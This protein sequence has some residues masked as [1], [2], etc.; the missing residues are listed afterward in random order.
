MRLIKRIKKIIGIADTFANGCYIAG[1]SLICERPRAK[2]S[3]VEKDILIIAN[4][5]SIKKTDLTHFITGE[6]DIAVLNDY[7]I[8]VKDFWTIKPK[9]LVIV[10]PVYFIDTIKTDYIID[11]QK[12]MTNTLRK[13]DWEFHVIT[14]FGNKMPVKNA[15][16]VYEWLPVTSFP[17]DNFNL[18]CKLL[19]KNRFAQVG[20][21][22]VMGAAL[23]YFITNMTNSVYIA[24]W[25]MSEFVNIRIDKNNILWYDDVHFYDNDEKNKLNTD[26][27]GFVKSGDFYIHMKNYS[28]AFFQ[29]KLLSDYSKWMHTRIINLSPYSF[30]DVF[31]KDDRYY[32]YGENKKLIYFKSGR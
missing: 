28:D 18:F 13:I 23:Y 16:I 4:G 17:R 32:F 27:V 11:T 31:E 3:K 26:D 6:Y 14:V 10:D 20:Y 7:P 5:P 22:N 15:K 1:H 30:V 2:W 12:N 29:F 9:Y 19:Y 21:R 24:G 8:K 25:D